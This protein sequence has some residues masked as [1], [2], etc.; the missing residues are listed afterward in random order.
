M[1]IPLTPSS[2]CNGLSVNPMSRRRAAAT[3]S[4]AQAHCQEV[5]D[6]SP[7]LCLLR[8]AFALVFVLRFSV[9]A[10]F[11]YLS[12]LAHDVTLRQWIGT[13][14]SFLSTKLRATSIRSWV[15]QRVLAIASAI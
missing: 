14:C 5:K 15:T 2:W 12:L 4:P 1:N 13:A 9:R 6:Q 7:E 11:I 8:D 10:D 3:R